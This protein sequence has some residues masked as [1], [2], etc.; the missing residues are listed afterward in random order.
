[1]NAINRYRE[2]EVYH[3]RDNSMVVKC[4]DICDG[5]KEYIMKRITGVKDFFKNEK[6][7]L[8]LLKSCKHVPKIV[9][10]F[11]DSSLTWVII[12]EYIPSRTL[13]QCGKLTVDQIEKLFAT[14]QTVLNILYRG[15]FVMLDIKPDNILVDDE[16]NFYI[17][18][19]GGCVRINQLGQ[20]SLVYTEDYLPPE[21]EHGNRVSIDIFY[22]IAV[23][24]VGICLYYA[25]Y[26]DINWELEDTTCLRQKRLVDRDDTPCHSKKIVRL[27]N[28]LMNVYTSRMSYSKM[29]NTKLK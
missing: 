29:L 1:M 7:C 4:A 17:I 20:S 27:L 28:K 19:F 12:M 13:L 22:S 16:F 9:Q 5:N 2:R 25:L 6:D 11:G 21:Y 3:K 8:D 18:D 15:G 10:T 23:W 14:F 26:G 24:S